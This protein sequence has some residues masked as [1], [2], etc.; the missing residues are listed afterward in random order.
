MQ[1]KTTVKSNFTSCFPTAG[2][3]DGS[4]WPGCVTTGVLMSGWWEHVGTT[5]L[6]I[7]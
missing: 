4:F 7:I 2:G 6:E 5:P 3:S 1:S